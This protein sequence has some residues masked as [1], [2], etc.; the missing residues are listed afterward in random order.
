MNKQTLSKLI[1]I[2]LAD[3]EELFRNKTESDAY[4]IGYLQGTLK[5]IQ[6]ELNEGLFYG[7]EK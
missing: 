5:T 4:I 6:K 7:I 3:S 2:T 1:E